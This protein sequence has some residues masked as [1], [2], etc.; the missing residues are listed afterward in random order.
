MKSN[1]GFHIVN[2]APPQ[3][4][5]TIAVIGIARGGTSFVASALAHLGVPFDRKPPKYE[6]VRLK[7]AFE[8]RDWKS[9]AALAADMNAKYD[10]WGWKLPAATTELASVL[11]L[12][13]NPR[14]VVVYKDACAVGVRKNALGKVAGVLDGISR[15]LNQY[16]LMTDALKTVAC[17]VL[18]VSYEKG[19]ASPETFVTALSAFVGVPG[20]ALTPEIL[21]RITAGIEADR[22]HYARSSSASFDRG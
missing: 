21:E 10:V 4:Q 18:L 9:F 22:D 14:I 2:D 11:P 5:A 12:V 8:A 19:I 16:R 6:H 17:P 3:P 7:K 20:A 1:P 13:R 15:C